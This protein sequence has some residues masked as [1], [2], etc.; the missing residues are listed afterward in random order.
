MFTLATWGPVRKALGPCSR[1]PWREGDSRSHLPR[2]PKTS[3]HNRDETRRMSNTVPCSTGIAIS[4]R[5]DRVA[6]F[7]S[8]SNCQRA[9]A[10]CGRQFGQ[11]VSLSLHSRSY[12][13]PRSGFGHP[14]LLLSKPDRPRHPADARHTRRRFAGKSTQTAGRPFGQQFG[15]FVTLSVYSRHCH[16]HRVGFASPSRR[17]SRLL[18]RGLSS[19][20]FYR[21]CVIPGMAVGYWPLG[22]GL[23]GGSTSQP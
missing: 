9:A 10:I 20:C 19:L 18:G 6:R 5:A 22:P 21:N 2:W 1:Q 14:S 12:H 11:V 15:Q 8:L 4:V 23:T 17:L 7:N 16:S 3:A 13:N